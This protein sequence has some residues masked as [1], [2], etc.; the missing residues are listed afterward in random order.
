MTPA[1]TAAPV[2]IRSPLDFATTLARVADA[3][4]AAGL[5]VFARIDHAENARN[6]GLQMPA[7]VVLLYGNARGGTPVMLAAPLAALDLPL[8]VL[9]H[10]TP[11]GTVIAYHPVGPL[12]E[13]AGVPKELLHRLDPAQQL[14]GASVGL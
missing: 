10:E 3:I 14:L 5:T 4:V 2:E 11:T 9:V 12:L 8:R 13:Q 6:A 1:G 7:T